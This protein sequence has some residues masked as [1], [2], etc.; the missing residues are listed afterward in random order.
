VTAGSKGDRTRRRLLDAAA[1]EVARLGPAGAGLGGIAAAAGLRT[2]SIYF[3]FAS[4]DELI[5]TM[6]EEG[7][8]ESLRRL[9]E[10]L[11]AV[12]DAADARARLRA[13]IRAHLRAL[14]ELDD[15]AAVVLDRG[16]SRA[17]PAAAEFRELRKQY[18]ARWR[19][20]VAEAQAAGALAPEVDPAE[21]RDLLFGAL[22]SVLGR[23][24]WTPDAVARSV[25]RL[26]GLA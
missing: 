1:A 4:K 16:T 24:G 17:V 14:H 11:A 25:E 6:L 20:L 9:E 18:G 19:E 10:A 26:I 22:N 3:H 8:R 15:Y 12:P 23:S 5:A 13:A 21:V 2:G 7:L